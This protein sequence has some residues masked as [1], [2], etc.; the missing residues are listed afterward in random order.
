MQKQIKATFTTLKQ[1][2]P[3]LLCA[4]HYQKSHDCG[5]CCFL[6]IHTFTAFLDAAVNWSPF[7]CAKDES[8]VTKLTAKN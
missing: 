2:D 1:F 7:N 5:R 6:A 8:S 3:S 4:L